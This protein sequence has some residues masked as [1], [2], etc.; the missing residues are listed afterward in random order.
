MEVD[1][2]NETRR[3]LEV[4]E[5]IVAFS[6]DPESGE[7]GIRTLGALADTPVFERSVIDYF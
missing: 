2:R 6:G 5:I 7:G 4:S 3:R 1:Q